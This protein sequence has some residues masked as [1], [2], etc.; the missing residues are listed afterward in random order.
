MA[1]GKVELFVCDEKIGSTWGACPPHLAV[2]LQMT[3]VALSP[4]VNCPETR[5]HFQDGML[6]E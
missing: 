2:H 6:R 3:I 1:T 4:V 5:F